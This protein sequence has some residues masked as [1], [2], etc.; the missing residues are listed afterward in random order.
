MKQLQ[1]AQRVLFWVGVVAFGLALL[2]VGAAVAVGAGGSGAAAGTAAS[3]P[4]SG[5]VSMLVQAT[6]GLLVSICGMDG[7]QAAVSQAAVAAAGAGGPLGRLMLWVGVVG[8]AWLART[9]VQQQLPWFAGWKVLRC[10]GN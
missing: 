9:I 4:A 10:M 6:A 2:T 1:T 8:V 5:L 7:T 3:T